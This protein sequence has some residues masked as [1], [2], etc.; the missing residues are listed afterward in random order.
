M[1]SFSTKPTDQ[2]F[3]ENFVHILGND[4]DLEGKWNELKDTIQNLKLRNIPKKDD[5]Q[6]KTHR[7]LT[8][9]NK[10]KIYIFFLFLLFECRLSTPGKS[11]QALVPKTRRM[12]N[13]PSYFPK[14]A[15]ESVPACARAWIGSVSTEML[16]VLLRTHLLH[17]K[18]RGEMSTNT[19]CA[20][21]YVHILCTCH[22][23]WCNPVAYTKTCAGDH[24]R[25]H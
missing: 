3:H 7:W 11:R 20:A 14:E 17:P 18:S 22:I 8:K 9:R 21:Q 13:P 16:F 12:G 1:F 24:C 4:K 6:T 2:S 25:L 10:M 5:F 15:L 19:L 23:H